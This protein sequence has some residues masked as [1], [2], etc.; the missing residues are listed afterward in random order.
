MSVSDVYPYKVNSRPI[1][2]F[3]SFSTFG[4][5]GPYLRKPQDILLGKH[6]FYSRSHSDRYC[7]SV[8]C[9]EHT[10]EKT[11]PLSSAEEKI[12]VR[13]KYPSLSQVRSLCIFWTHGTHRIIISKSLKL[14]QKIPMK[15]LFHYLG[16]FLK[17]FPQNFPIEKKPNNCLANGEKTENVARNSGGCWSN[18]C[19]LN[20]QTS[21]TF[22]I[23]DSILVPRV[24][25]MGSL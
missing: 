20:T 7:Q 13:K 12:E 10:F 24:Q 16:H 5:T 22:S 17:V 2:Q 15:I 6:S 11:V 1:C 19:F 25:Q 4:V 23:R 21:K 18:V 8:L 9:S 3:P 14:T